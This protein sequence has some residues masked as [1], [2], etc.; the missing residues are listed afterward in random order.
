MHG[1]AATSTVSCFDRTQ[2]ASSA[3]GSKFSGTVS[4][5][6]IVMPKVSSTHIT[7]S[8]TPVQWT[9]SSSE[10]RVATEVAAVGEEEV[11]VDVTLDSLPYTQYN[12]LLVITK[13]ILATK[14]WFEVTKTL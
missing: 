1:Q 12:D 10:R 8:G 5:S 11:L 3:T 6:S 9:V 4:S 2:Q 7:N 13:S 14:R